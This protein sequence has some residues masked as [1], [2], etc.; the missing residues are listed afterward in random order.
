MNR[1]TGFVLEFL[2]SGIYS[3]NQ[4]TG[5]RRLRLRWREGE[6][7]CR[8]LTPRKMDSESGIQSSEVARNHGVKNE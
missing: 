3:K 7:N 2:K 1:M 5:F 8:F 4:T 6:T